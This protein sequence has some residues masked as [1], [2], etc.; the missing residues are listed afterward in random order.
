MLLRYHKNRNQAILFLFS[1]ILF[2][3]AEAAQGRLPIFFHKRLAFFGGRVYTVF[4]K[5]H[6]CCAKNRISGF[7][8]AGCNSLPAVQPASGCLSK[9]RMH[10]S[11]KLR[12]R[13]YSLDERRMCGK[14]DFVPFPFICC[15]ETRFVFQIFCFYDVSPRS[16]RFR[17]D[18]FI[19]QP[20][21]GS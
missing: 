21:Q 18:F 13:Q 6:S 8:R 2:P 16:I 5:A 12:S 7:F 15:S 11:V 3:K 17:G 1:F 14:T 9:R 20:C 4:S 19:L 10:D